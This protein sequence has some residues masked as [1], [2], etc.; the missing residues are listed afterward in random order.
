[1]VRDRAK[2]L[3]MLLPQ[4][5]GVAASPVDSTNIGGFANEITLVPV[6]NAGDMSAGSPAHKDALNIHMTDPVPYWR[7]AVLEASAI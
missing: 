2:L 6:G 1:M 5:Q 7:A 3:A 4:T